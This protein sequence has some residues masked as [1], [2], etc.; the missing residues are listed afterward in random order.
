MFA[1]PYLDPSSK[2]G[3][4][5]EKP[6]E[7]TRH[8]AQSA[9][10]IRGS[11]ESRRSRSPVGR[12]SPHL[13][14]VLSHPLGETPIVSPHRDSRTCRRQTTC[15]NRVGRNWPNFAPREKR[16]KFTGAKPRAYPRIRADSA[17][18]ESH[19]DAQ[20]H[21]GGIL[22]ILANRRGKQLSPASADG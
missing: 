20:N 16:K 15:S 14:I 7:F 11:T 1:H 19:E 2:S 3:P 18:A 5:A 4:T 17:K 9:I 22:S 6:K 21:K 13:V 12:I 10:G 8:C